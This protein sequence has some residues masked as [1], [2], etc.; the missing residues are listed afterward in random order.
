MPAAFFWRRG[1]L[2]CRNAI[3]EAGNRPR[4]SLTDPAVLAALSPTLQTNATSTVKSI[5]FKASRDLTTLAGGPLGLALGA[6]V[7]WES[8]NTP[9]LPFTDTAEIVGLGY[10]AF[11]AKRRIQAVFGE[12]NAPVT[13]WLELNAALRHDKYSDFGSTTNPK[14]GFKVKPLDQL[15][16][17]G[18]YAEAFR[19]PGPAETGGSSFGFTSFGILSQGNPNLRPEE[20]RSYTLGLVFEPLANT[21]MTVDYWSVDR[22]NEII[23][24]DPNSILPAGACT[25]SCDGL[26]DDGVTP[27]GTTD[28]RHQRLA[29]VAANTFLFYDAAGNLTLTG[30]FQNA[31]KTKTDGVDLELRH[32]MNLGEAGRLSAQFNWT[33]VNKLE[34]TDVHGVALDYA[35]THGPL[36]QSSGT[37]SPKDKATFS[38]TWDRGPWAVTGA[39]NYVGPIRMVDHAGEVSDTDGTTVHN[40]NTG[41]DYAD[42][43]SG[44]YACGVFTPSGE[45]WNGCKLP[46]FTTFDLYARWNVTKHF[47]INVSIQN[48][49][50]KKA[51]FDPYLAIPYGIN[52][53][54]GYH[55]A[56]AVGRFFTV[57][58]KYTF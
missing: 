4:P 19:A 23:Q 6:E 44:N 36:V 24:A 13:P 8:A 18:T 10:S 35:G 25:T 49:F 57:G 55:Q 21:S 20:A 43:G 51:P 28:L 42:N 54:Q 17:R 38:L 47:E 12:L 9:P 22:K 14:I 30:F 41:V 27:D 1:A 56:G 15:A 16:I 53:N 48:L 29:G 39:V 58:A 37:G 34:R 46:S 45:I 31:A 7:R 40:A 33:H 52:Y 26:G 5:D 2:R 11:S 50:D 32:R 3:H